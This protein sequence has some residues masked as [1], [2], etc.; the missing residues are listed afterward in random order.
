[1]MGALRAQLAQAELR[2][3]NAETR[4]DTAEMLAKE[5]A[6]RIEDLRRMLRGQ[7]RQKS[8]GGSKETRCGGF[9][10]SHRKKRPF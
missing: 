9:K 10:S 4:A 8:G 3:L 2:V 1:M 5:R 7:S 6:D